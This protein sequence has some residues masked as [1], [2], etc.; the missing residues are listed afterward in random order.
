MVFTLR[1]GK[2]AQFYVYWFPFGVGMLRNG[3]IIKIHSE[4]ATGGVL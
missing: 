4:A 1:P 3:V 2:K